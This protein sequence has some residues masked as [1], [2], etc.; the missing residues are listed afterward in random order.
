MIVL[1][2]YSVMFFV[3]LL[4]SGIYEYV[5]NGERKNIYSLILIVPIFLY[6]LMR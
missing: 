2:A 6:V 4:L 5:Q 1:K 3:L